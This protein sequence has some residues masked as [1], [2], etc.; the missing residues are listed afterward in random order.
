MVKRF[1]GVFPIS[2]TLFFYDLN[3]NWSKTNAWPPTGL[4]KSKYHFL[5]IF[6]KV[7]KISVPGTNRNVKIISNLFLYLE[8]DLFVLVETI[9][10]NQVSTFFFLRCSLFSLCLIRKYVVKYDNCLR[11]RIF[12][13]FYSNFQLKST[14][15][16]KNYWDFPCGLVFEMK[17]E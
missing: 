5:I 3:C 6:S 14:I 12:Q 8:L 15:F 2:T 10:K 1:D 17:N 16:L 13:L 4:A 9:R 7:K 11:V